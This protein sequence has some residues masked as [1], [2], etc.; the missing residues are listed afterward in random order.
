MQLKEAVIERHF[1]RSTVPSVNLRITD[2]ILDVSVAKDSTHCMIAEALR[3]RGAW[4]INVNAEIVAFNIGEFRLM[5]PLPASAAIQLLRFDNREEVH[6]FAITLHCNTGFL[7]K[8]T[9]KPS[10]H[11]SGK[12]RPYQKRAKSG[13]KRSTRRV[14]GLRQLVHESAEYPH[15]H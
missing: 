15:K 10:T 3:Q 11:G 12:R 9:R 6:P 13:V 5:Y 7:R 1:K 8:V 4:S 14:H 2:K